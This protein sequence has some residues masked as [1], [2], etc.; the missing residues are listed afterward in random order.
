M[1]HL[2]DTVREWSLSNDDTFSCS[3]MDMKRKGIK[4]YLSVILN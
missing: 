4:E 3:D 1:L 2:A